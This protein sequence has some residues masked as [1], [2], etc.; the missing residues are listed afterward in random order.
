MYLK[1]LL[2][3]VKKERVV[4]SDGIHLFGLKYVHTHLAAFVSESVE[5]RYDP[6]DISEV[7]VF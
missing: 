2:L 3:R 4:H 5:I 6:R 1:I 7:R